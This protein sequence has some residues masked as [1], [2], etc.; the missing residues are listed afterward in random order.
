MG[1]WVNVVCW[2]WP[3]TSTQHTAPHDSNTDSNTQTTAYAASYAA[4]HAAS[5]HATQRAS[6]TFPLGSSTQVWAS[7]SSMTWRKEEGGRRKTRALVLGSPP[8]LSPNTHTHHI[9]TP[10]LYTIHHTTHLP[11]HTRLFNAAALQHCSSYKRTRTSQNARWRS[12]AP[13]NCF[14]RSTR[15]IPARHD[16]SHGSGRSA[17]H[18][19]AVVG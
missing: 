15:P 16:G 2:S 3:F 13:R 19:G 1:D 14:T 17:R 5:H 6:P 18:R 12:A 8:N 10:H 7:K 9:S 11:T 4:S